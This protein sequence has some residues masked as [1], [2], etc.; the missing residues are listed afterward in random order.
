MSRLGEPLK[1]KFLN[2]VNT[3][4]LNLAASVVRDVSNS[5]TSDSVM[6]CRKVVMGFGITLNLNGSWDKQKLFPHVRAI[7]DK[8]AKVFNGKPMDKSLSNVAM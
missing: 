3:L 4:Y 1:G 7:V 2:P 8:Y 5:R 6:Y